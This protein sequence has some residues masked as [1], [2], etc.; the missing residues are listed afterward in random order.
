MNIICFGKSESVSF[1]D[2]FWCPFVPFFDLKSLSFVKYQGLKDPW[3]FLLPPE[4][5]PLHDGALDL[6]QPPPRALLAAHRHVAPR[7]PRPDILFL[8]HARSILRQSS[9]PLCGFSMME[10][11]R[12]CVVW[13]RENWLGSSMNH[14]QGWKTV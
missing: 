1:Y 9:N 11:V 12:L 6:V 8:K 13:A 7:A 10:Q 14:L 5:D 2:T 3:L 4:P